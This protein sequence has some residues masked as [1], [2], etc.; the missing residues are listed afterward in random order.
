MSIISQFFKRDFGSE[1]QSLGENSLG[2]E[3]VIV[4]K[5]GLNGA[6]RGRSLPLD[7]ILG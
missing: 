7:I 4:G 6:G 3:N 5:H 1:N 2:K